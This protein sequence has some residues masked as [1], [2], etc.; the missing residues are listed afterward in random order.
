MKLKQKIER[1]L[2]KIGIKPVSYVPV[3]CLEGENIVLKS[4]KNEM[5]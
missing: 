3:S 4:K 5:V 2:N 1:F